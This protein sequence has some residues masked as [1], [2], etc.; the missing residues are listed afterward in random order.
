[1]QP[2][3]RSHPARRHPV[4]RPA[5]H[6]GAS[7][8]HGVAHRGW[9]EA[10]AVALL[11]VAALTPP[12]ALG[13]VEPGI[14]FDPE[15]ADIGDRVT[16]FSAADYVVCFSLDAKPAPEDWPVYLAA[17]RI[18]DPGVDDLVLL[19]GTWSSESDGA[20]SFG[21]TVPQVEPGPYRGYIECADG[22]LDRSTSDLTVGESPPATDAGSIAGDGSAGS[23]WPA[24]LVAGFGAFIVAFRRLSRNMGG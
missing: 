24:V 4:T 16:L 6:A 10:G 8:Q 1:M 7:T 13:A 21:F 22:R 11:A 15:R 17:D 19:R 18:E 9:L 2:R 23:S 12:T 20:V 5:R 14:Y 3:I